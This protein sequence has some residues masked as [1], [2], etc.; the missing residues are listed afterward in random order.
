MKTAQVFLKEAKIERKGKSTF[1]DNASN[2]AAVFFSIITQVV[3]KFYGPPAV[4]LRI[5]S[6]GL[7]LL[8]NYVR[9][10]V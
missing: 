9:T 8:E 6:H 2:Q 7:A 4:V 10:S 1:T 3:I 5:D